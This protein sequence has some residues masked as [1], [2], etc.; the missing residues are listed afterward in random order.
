MAEVIKRDPKKTGS[1][2]PVEKKVKKEAAAQEAVDEIVEEKAAKNDKK[3]VKP[4]KKKENALGLR[5]GAAVLWLLAIVCEVV[6]ILIYVE[7]IELPL[8]WRPLVKTI[9]FL[10]IDLIF[11]IIGS[12]LWKTANHKD[13]VSKKNKVKFWL[14]N[15]MG[16]IVCALAFIPFI[17]IALTD[18][19]ADPKTKKIAA[20]AAAIMLV[21]GGL[22]SYDWNPMSAEQ[23]S[24]AETVLD[25]YTL[26][27]TNGGQRYHIDQECSALVN[28]SELI[29]GTI[30]EAIHS[31][32][33]D[34]LCKF[35]MKRNA[36]NIDDLENLVYGA[37]V[38]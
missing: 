16:V 2:A 6:A 14:W 26:Y 12:Q 13:P 28:S 8:P 18:K 27:W 19:N 3:P 37:N 29:G 36:E 17:I 23:A 33:K 20:I 1:A 22:C 38:E 11:I 4:A 35:C 15:N 5:I 24:E 34:F 32:G 7:K 9:I 31:Y 21:I 30:D 10:V 25:G